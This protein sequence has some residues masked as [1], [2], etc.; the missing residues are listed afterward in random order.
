METKHCPACG[1]HKPHSE[2]HRR[3]TGFQTNCKVC[4]SQIDR[5]YNQTSD[6]KRNRKKVRD[7]ELKQWINSYKA[8]KGCTYC[9]EREPLFLDFHHVSDDKE[10]CVS[11]VK[12]RSRKVIEAEMKK[13][14]VVCCKCHR[15]IHAG[16][17]GPWNKKTCPSRRT[18]P[19]LL[20]QA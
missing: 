2:F 9:E 5:E 19:A 3:G 7:A 11:V 18:E 4:K 1:Q 17:K 15:M 16:W 13:C 12:R 6:K 8:D 20:R 14:I 10:F